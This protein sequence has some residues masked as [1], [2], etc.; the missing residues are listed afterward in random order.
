MFLSFTLKTKDYTHFIW[1]AF[2]DQI[3][4]EDLT[5]YSRISTSCHHICQSIRL[6]YVSPVKQSITV[7]K[8]KINKWTNLIFMT[9]N[10]YSMIDFVIIHRMCLYNGGD[11]RTKDHRPVPDPVKIRFRPGSDLDLVV[12]RLLFQLTH[13]STEHISLLFLRPWNIKFK[14]GPSSED[15]TVRF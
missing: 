3:H 15:D 8:D 12:P 4:F 13:T 2:D 11:G 9:S 14:V 5:I 10:V 6:Q 1:K 7:S